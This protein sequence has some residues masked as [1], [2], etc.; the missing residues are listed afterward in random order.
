MSTNLIIGIIISTIISIILLVC[1]W[2]AYVVYR[3][4]QARIKEE[5]NQPK[6]WKED[7]KDKLTKNE[8]QRIKAIAD[9][10]GFGNYVSVHYKYNGEYYYDYLP[11]YGSYK[12]KLCG[13]FVEF[14]TIET[15]VGKEYL[16]SRLAMSHLY[17]ILDLKGIHLLSLGLHLGEIKWLFI[18]ST[19]FF[20][21]LSFL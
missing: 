19:S 21:W 20:Y 2:N 4:E 14:T 17:K 13:Y 7:V 3:E 12:I 9:Y 16:D 18:L 10:C 8:A 5:K 11:H 15:I 6:D 1:F